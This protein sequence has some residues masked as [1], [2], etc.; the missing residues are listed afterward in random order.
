MIS[1][2]QAEDI[3]RNCIDEVVDTDEEYKANKPLGKFSIIADETVEDLK[4]EICENKEVGVP[5]FNH[6]LDSDELDDIDS[7][8]L[9]G[10]IEDIIRKKAKP[11]EE[12][13]KKGKGVRL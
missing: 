6:T 7:D 1:P 5:S 4:I 8:T 2:G 11:I 10:D 13:S 12:K 9:A 3:V